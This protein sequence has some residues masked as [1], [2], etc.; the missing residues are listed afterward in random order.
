MGDTLENLCQSSRAYVNLVVSYCGMQTAR[1]LQRRFGIPYVVG[2]PCG[3]FFTDRLAEDIRA[4]AADG[5]CRCSFTDGRTEQPKIAVIG[6][7]VF[8][9]SLAAA[10]EAETGRGVRSIAATEFDTSMLSH[11][12]VAARDEAELLPCF[13]NI[14]ILIADP[15]YRPIC[16]ADVKFIGIGHEGFSGRIFRNEIPDL[17]KDIMLLLNQIQ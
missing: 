1:I 5:R 3:K 6:E 12:D 9:G 2:R 17:A 8:G 16:P 14:R 4:S 11:N 7:G 10:I 15:L 13:Q